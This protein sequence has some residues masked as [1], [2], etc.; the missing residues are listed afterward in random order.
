MFRINMLY[1][2]CCK[3]ILTFHIFLFVILKRH[4]ITYSEGIGRNWQAICYY[5]SLRLLTDLSWV[6]YICIC[7][8]VPSINETCVI[9][10]PSV[11]LIY[12]V[13]LHKNWKYIFKCTIGLHGCK[14]L[15]LCMKF[16][17][18][19]YNLQQLLNLTTMK[20]NI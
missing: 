3:C 9:W 5:M 13:F 7:N 4:P 1:K 20:N 10:T 12:L 14:Y 16:D 19:S 8:T 6:E 17:H 18:L 15:W 2:K 11:C